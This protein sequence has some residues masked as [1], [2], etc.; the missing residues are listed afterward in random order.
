[1]EMLKLIPKWL[2]KLNDLI[3]WVVKIFLVIL[4][5][6][7][8]GVVFYAVLSRT[9]INASIAWAEE[10]SRILFIWLV[11]GGAVLALRSKEHLGLT[12][13]VDR[14]K[15]KYQLIF[16]VISWILVIVVTV[17]MIEGG[18]KIVS[19]VKFARTPAL[20]LPSSLKYQAVL[21]AGYLMILISIE[22]LIEAFGRLLQNLRHKKEEVG[23]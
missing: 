2:G 15:P 13:L 22:H 4:V 17:A 16:E 21:T 10:L 20:G 9:L 7:L 11:F 3:A 14:L 12:M 5:A 23:E 8:V 6:I 19:V 18:E 1:M